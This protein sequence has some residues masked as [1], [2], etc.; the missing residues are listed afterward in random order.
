MLIERLQVR[1]LL[2]FGPNGID[3]EMEPLN[4]LIGP[5]ACG[6]SNFLAALELLQAS[7]KD[8]AAYLDET[9][10]HGEW[11]WKG[12]ASHQAE[13]NWKPSISATVR[14]PN[15]TGA[16]QHDLSVSARNGD[17][18]IEEHTISLNQDGTEQVP[19]PDEISRLRQAYADIRL[20]RNWTIGAGTPARRAENAGLASNVLNENAD[21]LA[22]IIA[23]M[24]PS[25]REQLGD[26]L[27]RFDDRVLD[28][29]TPE[30]DGQV[31]LVVEERIN[32]PMPA[33]ALSGGMLRYLSLFAIL[34][35][36][37]PPPLIAIEEPERGLHPDLMME[38]AK[39][40]RAASERTQLVMTT[41]SQV[42]VDEMTEHPSSVVAFDHY[43]GETHCRR[44]D[45]AVMSLWKE[46]ESLGDV[47][48]AGGI[49]GNHW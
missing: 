25:R 45:P 16:L 14:L 32:G 31:S 19:S 39:L 33:S 9:G 7:A 49:G 36:P 21:N 41:H 22:T 5:N 24:S 11:L 27:R 10:G 37:N 8:T 3:L 35:D 38:I 29:S 18:E 20:Y 13:P 47:W 26:Y 34:L 1:G 12:P 4:V 17:W 42:V 43:D 23:G 15:E 6:K 2:S 44:V 48:A 30:Q 46:E 40:M 28:L